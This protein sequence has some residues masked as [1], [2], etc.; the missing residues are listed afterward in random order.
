M[1]YGVLE[2]SIPLNKKEG[3]IPDKR[4]PLEP[5]TEQSSVLLAE[6]ALRQALE[7]LAVAGLVKANAN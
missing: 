4:S 2:N 1:L 6:T 3:E 5:I 7:G